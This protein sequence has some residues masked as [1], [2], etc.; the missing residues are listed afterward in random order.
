[1]AWDHDGAVLPLKPPHSEYTI[2]VKALHQVQ[3]DGLE[4][5][6]EVP[7]PLEIVEIG[8]RI[9]VAGAPTLAQDSEEQGVDKSIF[10]L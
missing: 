4:V 10:L 9:G 5:V 8:M 3:V 2:R 1:M 6:L 7:L